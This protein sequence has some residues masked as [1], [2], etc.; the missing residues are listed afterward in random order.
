VEYQHKAKSHVDTNKVVVNK[1][2]YTF[3]QNTLKGIEFREIITRDLDTLQIQKHEFRNIENK[4][5]E[6]LANLM[7]R[8]NKNQYVMEV[9]DE[10]LPFGAPP[11]KEGEIL[12]QVF[13]ND[14]EGVKVSLVNEDYSLVMFSFIGCTACEIALADLKKNHQLLM[15]RI[16]IY[17]SSFQNNNSSLKKY[18]EDK[19]FFKNS[20]GRESN[21]IADFRLADAPTFVI[22]NSKGI[23]E[24]IIAGYEETV[25]H[26][27]EN[28]IRIDNR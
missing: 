7:N 19:P 23:V 24:K 8:F 14:I 20:F 21:M 27:I 17:Y 3:P 11:I 26:E 25:F 6:S 5:K 1:F 4:P 2:Q 22:I 15:D 28:I 10:S 9:K 13:F 16:N 18:L 12:S